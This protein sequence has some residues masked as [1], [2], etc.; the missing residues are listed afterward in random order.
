MR[1]EITAPV[2][3]FTGDSAGASFEQGTAHVGD[4]TPAGRARLAYFRSS[5]YG[6]RALD[7]PATDEPDEGDVP[8]DPAQ[9]NV[10]EVV[11]YLDSVV[12]DEEETMRVLLS[13][14]EGK[15]RK[16]ITER[17]AS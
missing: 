15:N 9:H 1:Y 14:A 11:E 3:G 5:G 16:T 2:S 8:F 7:V 13:E 12:D 4:D 10:D 6:V 17:S